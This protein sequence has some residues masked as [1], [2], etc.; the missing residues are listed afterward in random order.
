M[1]LRWCFDNFFITIWIR[2]RKV[3]S[4]T[5]SEMFR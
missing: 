1:E 5:Q 3:W 2:R 4:S